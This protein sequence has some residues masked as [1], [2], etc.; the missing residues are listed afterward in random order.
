MRGCGWF[1]VA[2]LL[3]GCPSPI[4]PGSPCER[5]SQCDAPLVCSAGRCREEC[6]DQRDCPLGARCVAGND[7]L[8][9][10]TLPQDRCSDAEPCPEDLECR[11]ALCYDACPSGT[12]P[13]GG[14][15]V[16]GVCE[17]PG[18]LPDAGR[19]DAGADDAAMSVDAGLDA[20]AGTAFPEHRVCRTDA[21]CDAGMICGRYTDADYVCRRPC[22]TQPDCAQGNTS[23]VCARFTGVDLSVVTMCSIPCELFGPEGEDGCP[24]G[25]T[26]DAL[27]LFTDGPAV[28]GVD[29]R[30]IG[31]ARSTQGE[32][33]ALAGGY[34]PTVCAPGYD[35]DGP[36]PAFVCEQLCTVGGTYGDPCPSGTSCANLFPALPVRF[37]GATV[38]T[39][40]SG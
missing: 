2:V 27:E 37:R 11:R 23:S 32:P 16:D 18:A 15:C 31:P 7:G 38:G 39:C 4:T 40:T 14:V 28:V 19:D 29:C 13:V 22:S 9:V 35:C 10:C 30:F 6:V 8:G 5:S 34:D 25:E 33:C 17:R 1:V 20:D 36:G 24:D 3:V 12:C 26:C 21:E